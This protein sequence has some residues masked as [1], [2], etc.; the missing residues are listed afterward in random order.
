MKKILFSVIL[1]LAALTVSA[2]DMYKADRARWMQIANETKPKLHYQTVKPVAVVKAVKDDKA[3]QGWRYEKTNETVSN[4]QSKNFKK[5]KEVTLDFGKHLV[6]YFRFH[7]KTLNR[8]QNAPIR[9]KF[10]FGELPA[11]LNTPPRPVEGRT[12]PCVDA[13]RDGDGDAG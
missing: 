4:L 7:T 2:D 8:C 10:F 6:G 3:F 1:L 13:G 11:E 9:L 12:E 5:V